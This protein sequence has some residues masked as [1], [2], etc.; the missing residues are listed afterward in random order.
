[1]SIS[2]TS[3][4]PIPPNAIANYIPGQGNDIGPLQ[5]V[6]W[7]AT[8][9]T[10]V[11][12]FGFVD[13]F[14]QLNFTGNTEIQRVT[15]SSS[16]PPFKTKCQRWYNATRSSTT[17]DNGSGIFNTGNTKFTLSSH[18]YGTWCF[19]PNLQALYQLGGSAN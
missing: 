6:D 2:A 8:A 13:E 10:A 12:Q 16:T 3:A 9:V 19:E 1:M 7:Q 15:Y 18:G 17:V 14:P 11:A 4:F 5:G